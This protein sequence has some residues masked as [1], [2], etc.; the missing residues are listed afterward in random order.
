MEGPG[1][2]PAAVERS[3]PAR[4]VSD[5]L[6]ASS[7]SSLVSENRPIFEALHENHFPHK[8]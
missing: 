7:E 1:I 8:N 4:V 6:A 3:A 5:P 2:G